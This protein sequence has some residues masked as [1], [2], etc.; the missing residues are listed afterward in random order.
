MEYCNVGCCYL[1][2]SLFQS[3]HSVFLATSSA[4]RFVSAV[5]PEAFEGVYILAA[6]PVLAPHLSY[7]AWSIIGGH[8]LSGNLQP[9]MAGGL[10]GPARLPP[11]PPPRRPPAARTLHGTL[12]R[13]RKAIV[14]NDTDILVD[15]WA[16]VCLA[17]CTC[18]MGRSRSIPYIS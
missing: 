8:S 18:Y 6:S 17:I 9:W 13:L 15:L 5:V 14:L 11:L 3:F 4:V 10:A 2:S 16:R 1:H 12:Q 7:T